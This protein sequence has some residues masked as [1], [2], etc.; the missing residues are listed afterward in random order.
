MEIQTTVQNIQQGSVKEIGENIDNI[1]RVLSKMAP[2]T[3]PNGLKDNVDTFDSTFKQVSGKVDDTAGSINQVKPEDLEEVIKVLKKVDG[4][5]PDIKSAVQHTTLWTGIFFTA[6]MVLFILSLFNGC[7]RC[8]CSFVG[9][10]QLIVFMLLAAFLFPFL[11]GGGDFCLNARALIDD[12]AP[13]NP[14]L[15]YYL[16]CNKTDTHRIHKRDLPEIPDVN[17]DMINDILNNIDKYFDQAKSYIET[18]GAEIDKGIENYLHC[19][20]PKDDNFKEMCTNVDQIKKIVG[21]NEK[22]NKETTVKPANSNTLSGDLDM[23]HKTVKDIVNEIDCS[24]ISPCL[25][26]TLS[27]VCTNVYLAIFYFTIN[28]LAAFLAV[29][30]L[31]LLTA[32]LF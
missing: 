23:M 2:E 29:W 3:I 24:E 25:Y 20:A 27:D 6:L 7:L 18:F 28:Y 22:K 16:D 4:S 13:Q 31:T 11:V 15:S 1:Q 17:P 21:F 26:K 9:W 30:F 10:F 8:C 5:C 12:K 14:V 19:S 32:F